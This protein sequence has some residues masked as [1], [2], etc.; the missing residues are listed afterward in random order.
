MK[1]LKE[2]S[3]IIILFIITIIL[4][5][6]VFQIQNKLILTISVVLLYLIS[7][8]LTNKNKTKLIIKLQKFT[9]NELNIMISYY[10]EI[11]I[12]LV[13]NIYLANINILLGIIIMFLELIIFITIIY[14]N[15]NKTM[16]RDIFRFWQIKENMYRVMTILLLLDNM[17]FS[18]YNIPMDSLFIIGY[19][20]ININLLFKLTE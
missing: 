15:Y 17:P 19:I 16:T 13:L 11:F 5:L 12:L 18:E 4:T 6:P 1:N 7:I 20:V 14:K 10:S 9:K 8:F 3:K 2:L